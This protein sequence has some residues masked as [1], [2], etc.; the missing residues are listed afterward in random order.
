MGLKPK[1]RV[2]GSKQADCLFIPK[3]VGPFRKS[4]PL[5]AWYGVHDTEI[6]SL[7]FYAT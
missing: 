5:K 6:C 7:Y 1:P 2:L 3:T 4:L